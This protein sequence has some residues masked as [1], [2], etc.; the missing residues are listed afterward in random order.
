MKAIER[1]AETWDE[2]R[3]PERECDRRQ[4]RQV[5]LR[6]RKEAKAAREN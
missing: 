3:S 6:A 2:G 1:R 4:M 5:G